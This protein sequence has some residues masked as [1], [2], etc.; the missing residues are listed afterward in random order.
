MVAGAHS[1]AAVLV[2]KKQYSILRSN[3]GRE[4]TLCILLIKLP[5]VTDWFLWHNKSEEENG[6]DEIIFDY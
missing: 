3:R 2:F 6:S 5:S 4:H 1:L